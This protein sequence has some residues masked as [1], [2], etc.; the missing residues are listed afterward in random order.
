MTPV[1]G[2]AR[3]VTFTSFRSEMTRFPSIAPATG[4]RLLKYTAP[5]AVA[6]I[7][8]RD[9][10]LII[11]VGTCEQHGPHLPLGCATIIAEALCG[12]SVGD[13]QACCAR[14][15]SNMA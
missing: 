3:G 1:R 7:L 14:R 6:E 5:G 12:R 11:P 10:R 9:P 2:A 13:V 8:A 4:A 15:P